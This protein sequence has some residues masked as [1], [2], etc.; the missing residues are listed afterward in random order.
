[1]TTRRTHGDVQW[2]VPR[3]VRPIAYST[4]ATSDLI[5]DLAR[6]WLTF[7]EA[8]AVVLYDTEAQAVLDAYI[9]LG[10][11]DAIMRNMGVR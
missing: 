1:M 6:D 7:S 3:K 11:G 2:H 10:F 4:V 8:R 9:E 5:A